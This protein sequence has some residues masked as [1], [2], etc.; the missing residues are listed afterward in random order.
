MSQDNSLKAVTIALFSNTAIAII[1]FIVAFITRSSAMM[2]EAIHSSADCFNQIFLLIGNKRTKKCP[3]EQHSFG[4][5]KEEYFWGFMVAI[6][7]FFIGGGFSLY[8]GIHKLFKPEPIQN[9]IW[10]FIVLSIGIILEANS[11]RIAY[12]EFKK[13]ND[14][15][16]YRAIIDMSNTNLMVILLEDFAALLGLVI[17]LITTT[18]ALLISPIFDAIGSILVGAILIS[19][20]YTLSN[21]LRKL[22]IG[23]SVPRE[24][25]N[26]I[27]HIIGEYLIVKHINKLQTMFIGKNQFMILISLDVEDD[28]L[29]YDVED[30]IEQIKLDITKKYPN[31][32]TIYIEIKDSVRNNKV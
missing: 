24:V 20:S 31:A 8:E 10:S 16:F 3:N 30:V 23:E 5:G 22:I 7:L 26:D 2:A 1:K 32:S 27:K 11:F 4:Y 28:T 21:E 13:D 29:A 6:L 17:V 18:L 12:K 9:A 19:I 15:S 25:R 14:S